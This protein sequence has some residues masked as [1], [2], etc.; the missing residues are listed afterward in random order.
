MFREIAR[1]LEPEGALVAA[2]LTRHGHDW[3]RERL[4]DQWLGFKQEELE[5]WLADTGMV[6]TECLEVE[7]ISGQQSV[8]L[9][10]AVIHK[11]N[12]E[13]LIQENRK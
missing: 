9:F 7:A 11:H 6:L 10:K 8:L 5:K 13:S 3:A 4:A 1:V 12:S 2:D